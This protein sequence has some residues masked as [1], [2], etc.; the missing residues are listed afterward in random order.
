MSDEQGTRKFP[1]YLLQ[2][3]GSESLARLLRE[4]KL[5]PADMLPALS[6]L[7]VTDVEVRAVLRVDL[8]AQRVRGA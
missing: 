1:E 4:I 3:G 5:D 7:G 8:H 6:A 2:E